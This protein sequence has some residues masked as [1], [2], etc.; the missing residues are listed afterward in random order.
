[1]SLPAGATRPGVL[2]LTGAL[3]EID[4]RFPTYEAGHEV[5]VA[6]YKEF[7]D[8]LSAWLIAEGASK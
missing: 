5:T 6:A 8:D 3:P 4:I 1:M 2:Q 7:G